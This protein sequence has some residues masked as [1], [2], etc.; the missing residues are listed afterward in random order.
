MVCRLKRQS[1]KK[2][3]FLQLSK[4]SLSSARVESEWFLRHKIFKRS[5]G[6]YRNCVLKF[7]RSIEVV[8]FK[9]MLRSSVIWAPPEC[10]V[11]FENLC[12]WGRPIAHPHRAT[13]WLDAGSGGGGG[14]FGAWVSSLTSGLFLDAT[15]PRARITTAGRD[16]GNKCSAAFTLA[17]RSRHSRHLLPQRISTHFQLEAWRRAAGTPILRRQWNK[18][19]PSPTLRCRPDLQQRSM[20]IFW[21][22]FSR[23]NLKIE[24]K[25][26][27]NL[28]TWV[29]VSRIARRHPT[30][31]RYSPSL[32]LRLVYF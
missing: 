9:K 10:R 12:V 25:C 15:L 11:L 16:L 1:S 6:H 14:A 7:A 31:C 22:L 18:T 30:C 17:P 28:G 2:S 19:N 27:T 23:T 20:R 5:S 32:R 21:P 8:L 3:S 24:S 29:N 26:S 13:L 4:K